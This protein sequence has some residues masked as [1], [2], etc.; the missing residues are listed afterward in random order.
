MNNHSKRLK[1]LRI[2]TLLSSSWKSIFWKYPYFNY[3]A[4]DLQQHDKYLNNFS[5]NYN[6][7]I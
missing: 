3:L 7:G 6:S 4:S 5:F 1:K 2:K